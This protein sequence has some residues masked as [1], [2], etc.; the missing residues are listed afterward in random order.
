MMN[1]IL[2]YL[3]C[4]FSGTYFGVLLLTILE[5]ASPKFRQAV[6]GITDRVPFS[7]RRA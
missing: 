1:E 5:N 4:Y 2:I 6:R 7:V 3:C